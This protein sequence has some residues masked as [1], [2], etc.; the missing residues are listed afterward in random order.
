MKGLYV[1]TDYALLADNLLAAVEAA[2]QGGASMVQYRDKSTANA[3]RLYEAQ[4][5]QAL[6]ERYKV[7]LII[8]DDIRL[9]QAIGAGVHLGRTD[10]SI[11]KAR[12]SLGAKAIIGA[13]C[14]NSLDFARQAQAEG[15]NYLAFGAFYPSS[16]KPQAELADRQILSQAKDLGLPIVA[17][18][19]IT[20]D[21]AQPLIDA[22]ADC[23]AVISDVFARPVSAIAQRAQEFSRLFL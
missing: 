20:L 21:N 5:L 11:A 23:I 9:A 4:Q 22:G 13:T 17:I 18:G 14:H 16:S 2:L 6:C 15:A 8:N 10:G 1:I 12:R 7:P 19:G 3:R